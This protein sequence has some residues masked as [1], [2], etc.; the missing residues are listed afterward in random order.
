MYH[1][2]RDEAGPGITQPEGRERREGSRP[3]E[4][5]HLTQIR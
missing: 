2:K 5:I 3:I 1:K 4:H